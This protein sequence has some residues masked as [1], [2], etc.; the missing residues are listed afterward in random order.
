LTKFDTIVSHLSSYRPFWETLRKTRV[1]GM[2]NRG[3]GQKKKEKDKE[4]E[5]E[6]ENE[7]KELT[8]RTIK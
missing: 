5:K 1:M 3:E 6:K 4:K 8:P 7:K 2:R